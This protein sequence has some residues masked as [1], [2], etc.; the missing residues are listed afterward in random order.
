MYSILRRRRYLGGI[1]RYLSEETSEIL[2]HA[3]I[4]SKLDK[5]NSLLYGL[6]K[7]LLNGLRSIQN[8]AARIV[9]LSKRFDHITPIMFKLHW[10]RL[11]YRIHFKILLL[12][13]KCLNGLAPIYLSELLRYSISPRLLRSSSQNFLAVPRSRSKTYGDNAFSVVAPKLWNQLP[14]ELRG[15]TSVDQ[16]RKHLKTYLFKLA[17]DV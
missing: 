17:Y 3:F 9:T 6:P 15:A 10:L 1:R 5:C 4:S 2:V 8:T 13:Y 16:F 12:V 7:H 14:P 11:S